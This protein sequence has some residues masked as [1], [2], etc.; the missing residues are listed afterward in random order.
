MT[1]P[2]AGLPK[3]IENLILTGSERYLEKRSMG[4]V[5]QGQLFRTCEFVVLIVYARGDQT[6]AHEPHGS[7]TSD[8]CLG[9]ILNLVDESG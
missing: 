4:A 5:V 3:K 1:I 6:V 9:S 2:I 8:L 7:L